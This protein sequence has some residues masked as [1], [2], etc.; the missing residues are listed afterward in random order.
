MALNTKKLPSQSKFVRPDALESGTYP[1]RLV[2]IID[3]GLQAQR[4]YKGEEKEPKYSLYTTYELADEF[5]KDENGDDITTKPR[6]LSEEFPLHS[7]E[8]DKAKSTAR[9]MALDPD[10]KYDG[11]WAELAGAAAMITIT[12][13]RSKKDPSVIYN[14][15]ASVQ[16]MR[17]KDAA[18]LHELKNP[19]KVFDLG[20]PD[21]EIFLSLPTWLQDRIKGNL[22]YGGSLLEKLVEAGGNA[23]ATTTK[24]STSNGLVGQ[25][26]VSDDAPEEE[27]EW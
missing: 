2:Q 9:Y 3:L 25:E 26:D 22:E 15:I 14:N 19:P 21:M 10:L 12:Q 11:D 13:A 4:P 5:M 18:R 20:A 23:E 24:E 7:L 16:T 6:W 1:S 17:A 27:A 8:A